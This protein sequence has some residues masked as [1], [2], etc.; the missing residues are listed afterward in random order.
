M[1]ATDPVA[2]LQRQLDEL[3]EREAWFRARTVQDILA[4]KKTIKLL[5]AELEETQDRV[6]DRETTIHELNLARRADRDDRRRLEDDLAEYARQLTAAEA[7]AAAAATRLQEL[8]TSPSW[9]LTAP[10]RQIAKLFRQRAAPL[11][12]S[13][14]ARSSSSAPR[15]TYF[16]HTS[17]FRF[18]RAPRFTL[19]GWL[20]P[21]I[22]S[23]LLSLRARLDGQELPVTSELE[24]PE[25]VRVYQLSSDTRPGFAIEVEATP[26]LHEFVVEAQLDRGSWATVVRTPVRVLGDAEP[27]P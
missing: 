17:L 11:D 27:S 1:S 9:R 2:A 26:G 6:R 22:G 23:R 16:F 14:G 19:R 5:Q 21:P 4:L 8:R 12:P 10:L 25:V 24:E 7:T 20:L 13:A 18:H 3:T 15:F